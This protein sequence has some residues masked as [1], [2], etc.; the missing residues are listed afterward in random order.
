[1]NALIRQAL[2]A[3]FAAATLAAP[4]AGQ[5]VQGVT[6][7]EIAIGTHLDLSGPVAPAMPTLRNGTQMRFDEANERGGVHGRKL[8]LIVEDNA[9]QP[10]QAVRAMQKL[11]RNDNVFAVINAFGTG[12]N[13]AAVKTAA[14]AKVLYLAPWGASAVIQA[15]AKSPL[16]FTTVPNY[17]NATAVG[18]SWAIKHLGAKKVAAIYQ[19]D[20][21]GELL[22]RGYKQALAAHGLTSVAEAS[23]KPGDLDFSSQVARVRNAGADLIM[24]ATV[25]RE[26]VGV[27]NE[28]RKIGWKEVKVLASVPGTTNIVLRLGKEA[29][30][31]LY[32]TA[33]WRFHYADSAPAPVKAWIESYKKRFNVDPDENSMM[34]YTYAD[35]FVKGLEAAGRD[36]TTEKFVAA[37]QRTPHEDIFGNPKASFKNNHI[38]PE[39]VQI[40]QVKSGRWTPISPDLT[41][42]TK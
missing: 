25:T 13:L 33:N 17:D 34:A 40:M 9:Y 10:A 37:L 22:L 19:G 6:A 1:M 5:G 20:A 11:A 41:T 36:L 39:T 2:A 15:T 16:V 7:T 29:T 21:F 23:Y 14:E 27:M 35:W 12:T 3:C 42:I 4:A 18:L 31:G 8:R 28:I 24:L 30:E 38:D 26:T 32:G